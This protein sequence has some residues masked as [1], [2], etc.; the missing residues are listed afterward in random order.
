M[1]KIHI[2][3]EYIF[4]EDT[5]SEKIHIQVEYIFEKDTYSGRI[6]IRG[7]YIFLICIFTYSQIHNM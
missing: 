7:R 2:R 1:E 5:D 6:H 4:E 3:V